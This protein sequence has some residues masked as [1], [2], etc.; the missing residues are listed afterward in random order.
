MTS[1]KVMG[2]SR[3]TQAS[4]SVQHSDNGFPS[5]LVSPDLRVQLEAPQWGEGGPNPRSDGVTQ[6][7]VDKAVTPT[8]L[9]P[10]S[11]IP[12][13]GGL[14]STIWAAGYRQAGVTLGTVICALE[15]TDLPVSVMD[16]RW[17]L[18]A[19]KSFAEK[20]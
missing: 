13:A 17:P 6:T 11:G 19:A 10:Q 2:P 4:T 18:A 5:F 12:A 1:H 16:G 15:Q 14:E 9:I 7:L 8:K 20:P 3:T